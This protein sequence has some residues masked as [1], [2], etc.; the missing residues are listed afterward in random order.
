[1]SNTVKFFQIS[2]R[3]R[4]ENSN[5]N[6]GVF[7]FVGWYKW[8]HAKLTLKVLL[9]CPLWTFRSPVQSPFFGSNETMNLLHVAFNNHNTS[10]VISKEICNTNITFRIFYLCC[11][12]ITLLN[13]PHVVVCNHYV[14]WGIINLILQNSR[15]FQ[16]ASHL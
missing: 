7:R 12:Q 3:F 2:I 9:L 14:N 16:L 8:N 15:A 4:S 13:K 1:M 5:R 11:W 6:I 10:E